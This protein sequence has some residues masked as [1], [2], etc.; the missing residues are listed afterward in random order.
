MND[1][2]F[3]ITSELLKDRHIRLEQYTTSKIFTTD[4]FNDK[5]FTGYEYTY[6]QDGKIF[7]PL[8]M[9]LNRAISG[10]DIPKPMLI[11]PGKFNDT[12]AVNY[13]PRN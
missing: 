13:S 7:T 3:F 12:Q 4:D 6:S 11:V 9:M 8:K 2:I 5:Y 10:S 1:I